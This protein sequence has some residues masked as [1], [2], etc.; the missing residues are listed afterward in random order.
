MDIFLYFNT[1]TADVLETVSREGAPNICKFHASLPWSNEG[2][3]VRI[4]YWDPLLVLFVKREMKIALAYF[5]FDGVIA[6]TM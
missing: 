6:V 2:I 3:I 4:K 1:K 5:P